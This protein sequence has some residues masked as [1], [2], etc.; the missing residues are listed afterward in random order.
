VANGFADHF[1][2]K[3]KSVKHNLKLKNDVY[4]GMKKLLVVERFFMND[5]DIS[6]R[7]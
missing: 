2:E 7:P 1:H 5:S 4:N 3:I 6:E